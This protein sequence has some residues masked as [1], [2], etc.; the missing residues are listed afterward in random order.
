MLGCGISPVPATHRRLSGFPAGAIYGLAASD[1]AHTT[2][3]ACPGAQRACCLPAPF[4]ISRCGAG[5]GLLVSVMPRAPLV[6]S[7][8]FGQSHCPQRQHARLVSLFM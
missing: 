4:T 1:A 8:T 7:A 6:G 2:S 5:F 3:G